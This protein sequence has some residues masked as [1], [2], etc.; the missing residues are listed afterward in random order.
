[1]KKIT[2]LTLL[3]ILVL[4]LTACDIDSLIS[5]PSTN[6]GDTTSTQPHMALDKN[7]E[8]I[9]KRK[10]QVGSYFEMGTYIM[11]Y[12]DGEPWYNE[13]VW[14]VIDVDEE[15]HRILL[16]SNVI[17]DG[18]PYNVEPMDVSWNSCTLRT[19]LNDDF[20]NNAFSA[21]E[22]A[23]IADTNYSFGGE[24][25]TD[26]LF[27]L[28]ESQVDDYLPVGQHSGSRPTQTGE[29]TR[30]AY[31]QGVDCHTSHKT[32][33]RDY[34]FKDGDAYSSWSNNAGWWLLT[35]EFGTTAR[36]IGPWGPSAAG[37]VKVSEI[38]GVRPAMWL[39]LSIND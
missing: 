35:E 11:S 8:N 38:F 9:L 32:R 6:S 20:F 15:N 28:T 14:N 23:I 31:E 1:M 25:V 26:K 17:L 36:F 27:L 16:I 12:E 2:V 4:T 24:T 3:L 21:S 39:D 37:K 13:I 18:Q 22:Q 19:W 5:S 7:V 29:A 33:G 10:Y 34:S 30:Y